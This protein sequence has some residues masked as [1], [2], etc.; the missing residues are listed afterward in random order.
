MIKAYLMGQNLWDILKEAGMVP[1]DILNNKVAREKSNLR[2][3]KMISIL[4]VEDY[5]Y[6]QNM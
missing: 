4:E 6:T 3:R 5:L 2:S 1:M